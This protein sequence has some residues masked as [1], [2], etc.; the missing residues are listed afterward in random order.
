[1]PT[2]LLEKP[3]DLHM[4]FSTLALATLAS[5][6]KKSPD[7]RDGLKTR[8]LLEP[9]E[10]PPLRQV[11]TEELFLLIGAGQTR[12]VPDTRHPV[13]YIKRIASVII[14]NLG[15]TSPVTGKLQLLRLQRIVKFPCFLKVLELRA[16]S[17]SYFRAFRKLR[18]IRLHG[19]GP[20]GV[21]TNEPGATGTGSR[22]TYC[23]LIPLVSGPL[24]GVARFDTGVWKVC[25]K[26]PQPA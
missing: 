23:V 13:E 25:E 6:V 11:A 24:N 1:M 26:A 12:L 17:N 5:P 22:N 3:G 14:T 2:R 4:R 8:R 9:Q 7:S 15:Y 18:F 10:L 20:S 19:Q 21:G 16:I